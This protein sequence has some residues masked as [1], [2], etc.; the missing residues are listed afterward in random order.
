MRPSSL[1]RSQWLADDDGVA[2]RRRSWRTFSKR[3][4]RFPRRTRSVPSLPASLRQA[5]L[6]RTQIELHPYLP[7]HALVSYLRAQGI[8]PQAYSPL[9]STDSPLLKDPEIVA[10][11]KKWGVGV[12][13]VLVSYQGPF[14]ALPFGRKRMLM[15]CGY[16]RARRRRP[17]QERYP[18]AYRVE[19]PPRCARCGRPPD[20]QR[21]AQ[22][23]RKDAEVG[24]ARL[25]HGPQVRQLVIPVERNGV[26]CGGLQDS[27]A[28]ATAPPASPTLLLPRSKK[29]SHAER[30]SH[31]SAPPRSLHPPS[32]LHSPSLLPHRLR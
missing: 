20:P 14:L 13:T 31:P 6:L 22:G 5:D 16:S 25:E 11:A 2:S 8:T 29:R 4:R 32:L 23:A 21:P 30:P 18:R 12:G 26:E 10:I 9:G 28:V 17:P 24:Q 27:D 15:R 1:S 3:P 19:P 7:Q